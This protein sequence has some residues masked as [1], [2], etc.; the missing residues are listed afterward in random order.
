MSTADGLQ[1]PGDGG[2]SSPRRRPLPLRTVSAAAPGA[3][4]RTDESLYLIAVDVV[5][6]DADGWIGDHVQYDDELRQ[7]VGPRMM[8]L[9][10]ID[11]H[12]DDEVGHPAATVADE[13]G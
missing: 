10:R 8:E 1:G 13:D 12:V 9:I 7:D 2:R 4:R 11:H 3:D 6:D 5:E